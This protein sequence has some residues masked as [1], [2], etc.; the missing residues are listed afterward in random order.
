LVDGVKRG[1]NER[2]ISLK[3]GGG[4]EPEMFAMRSK[5]RVSSQ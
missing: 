5:S 4:Q 3:H 1:K 2:K